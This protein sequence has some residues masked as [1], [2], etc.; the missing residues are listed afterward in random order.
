[1]G[2]QLLAIAAGCRTF[3]MKWVGDLCCLLIVKNCLV[4]NTD[5][6]EQA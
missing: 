1:L 2:H 6:C 4:V 3:K 5:A